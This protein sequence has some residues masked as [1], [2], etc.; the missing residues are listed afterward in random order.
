MADASQPRLLHSAAQT[1]RSPHR[2][3]AQHDLRANQSWDVSGAGVAGPRARS[4]GSRT[5]CSR[6]LS[7]ELTP[8]GIAQGG[9]RRPPRRENEKL[10]KDVALSR[11]AKSTDSF[12]PKPHSDRARVQATSISRNCRTCSMFDRGVSRDSPVTVTQRCDPRGP[13]GDGS[14]RV[15]DVAFVTSRKALHRARPRRS[16]RVVGEMFAREVRVR[17]TACRSA[18]SNPPSTASHF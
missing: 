4:D 16:P 12:D 13:R 1:S 8:V 17:P 7:T 2:A 18:W 6:W 10:G 11:S 9:C 15:H 5:M 3:V 14:K